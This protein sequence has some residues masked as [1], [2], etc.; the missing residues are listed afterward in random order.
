[1]VAGVRMTQQP[2]YYS[3]R[4]EVAILERQTRVLHDP[5]DDRAGVTAASTWSR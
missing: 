5:Y 2:G 4:I 3:T 1:M